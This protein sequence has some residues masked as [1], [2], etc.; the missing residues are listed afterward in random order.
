[1]KCWTF[2]GQGELNSCGYAN[3]MCLFFSEFTLVFSFSVNLVLYM[4][5]CCMTTDEYLSPLFLLIQQPDLQLPHHHLPFPL[6]YGAASFVVSGHQG[7]NVSEY[8]I[9]EWYLFQ[10]LL[11]VN[12]LSPFNNAK[13]M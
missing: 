5:F 1:M 6:S 13:S 12:F 7:V 11:T 10:Q 3:N 8:H 9:G 2:S 4:S